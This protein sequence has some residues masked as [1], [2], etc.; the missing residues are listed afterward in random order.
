VSLISRDL[1]GKKRRAIPFGIRGISVAVVK[2]EVRRNV[3]CGLGSE[4]E[5]WELIVGFVLK[6][7]IWEVFFF[8]D[9]CRHTARAPITSGTVTGGLQ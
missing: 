3:G 8:C 7:F 6:K 9:F 2:V 4:S 1:Q 5:K